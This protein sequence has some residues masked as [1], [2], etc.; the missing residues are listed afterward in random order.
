M[1]A[2]ESEVKDDLR[3]DLE[4]A[5][6]GEQV[7][8][9]E[10]PEVETPPE[11][12]AGEAEQA[13]ERDA[14]GRFVAK[15]AQGQPAE[16]GAV[17]SGEAKPEAKPEAEAKPEGETQVTPEPAPA[18]PNGWTADAKAKWHELPAEVQ[19][20]VNKREADVAKFTSKSDDERNFG[21][22]MH[23]AVS[24]YMAQ[25]QAEGGTPAEAVKSLLN[26]A[27]IL[28]VGAPEQKLQ[29][30]AQTAKQFGVDLSQLSQTQT[31]GEIPPYIQPLYQEVNQLKGMLTQRDQAESQRLQ[32]EIQSEIEA[33]ASDPAHPHY[34]EVK[35]HMAA[36]IREGAAKDLKDAYEQACW[37]RPDIRTTLLAQQRT[38]EEQKRKAEAKRKAE[39]AKRRGVSI[40]GGPG[41]TAGKSA[42][43]DRSLRE[44]LEAQ[45]AASSGTV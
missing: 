40:T 31:Q 13:R 18:P 19:A 34:G 35:G 21:R 8:T 17:E 23:R 33:F 29:L 2:A 9:P 6:K 28:R 27:Y 39:E 37:A 14:Q 11:E 45:M 3:A 30:L 32:S 44:E 22:E 16:E 20:A 4:A 43:D 15:D 12:T 7:E 41:N 1:S 36:L 10:T 5:F 25:I 42:P 38:E 26:T 24:P